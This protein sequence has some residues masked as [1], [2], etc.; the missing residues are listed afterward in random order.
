MSTGVQ[1]PR[2]DSENRD[3]I[4]VGGAWVTA[5]GSETLPVTDC[6]TEA[7]IGRIRSASV[8]DVDRAVHA[9]HAALPKWAAVP[10]GERAALFRKLADELKARRETIAG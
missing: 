3:A 4:F 2:P 6:G 8:A 5:A 1:R 10:P 7:V 9:A